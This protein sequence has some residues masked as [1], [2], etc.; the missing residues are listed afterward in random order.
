MSPEGCLFK[1]LFLNSDPVELL[2]WVLFISKVGLCIDKLFPTF[3]YYHLFMANCVLWF[4]ELRHHR[5]N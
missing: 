4:I 3:D 5:V 1:G 2:N